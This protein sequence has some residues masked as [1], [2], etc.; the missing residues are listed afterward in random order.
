[1][2]ACVLTHTHKSGSPLMYNLLLN[3]T[4]VLCQTIQMKPI[5]QISKQLILEDS[6]STF[7]IKHH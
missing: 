1:M 4:Q 6:Q 2:H 5:F 7:K 3:Y